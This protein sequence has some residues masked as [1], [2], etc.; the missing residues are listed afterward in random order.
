MAVVA[1]A[2]GPFLFGQF[3]GTDE[4]RVDWINDTVKVAL[5]GSGY[6]PNQDGHGF[7]SDVQADEISAS[8]YTA[9]GK[10]LAEKAESYDAATNK[11][12]LKAA[13]I[14]WKEVSLTARYAAIYKDTG[15][16]ATSPLIGYV[17][18]GEDIKASSGIFKIEWDST[19]G[20]VRGIVL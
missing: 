5:L 9:G 14:T 15:A 7:L 19:D 2:Y 11:V 16:A 8:N 13:T 1:H 6:V 12:R 17:D 20:I 4:R 18:F 3:S 10:E